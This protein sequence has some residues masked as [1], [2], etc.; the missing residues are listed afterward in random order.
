MAAASRPAGEGD[1]ILGVAPRIAYLPAGVDECAEVMAECAR[2]KLR[3]AFIGGGTELGLGRAP[4][5]LDA[6][7]RTERMPRILDYAPADMVLA[8]EAGATLAQVQAAAREHGQMLAIDPPR[9]DRAT[10]GGVVATGAFG[11]RRARYGAIRDLIIGVTL[12]RA[13]GVVARGGGKVVKN[14]AGFDLPKLAC[15]SLGTLGMIA[16]ATFRLHPLPEAGATAAF[17]GVPA[18]KVVELV[19]AARKAQLEP[20][21]AAALRGGDGRF[22][23]GVRFEGFAKGVTQQIARVVEVARAAG[24]AG[25]A[26][27]DEGAFWRRHDAA[28]TSGSLR[29]KLAALPARLTAVDALVAPLLGALRGGTFVW[30]ATLGFG[31]VCGDAGDAAAAA[32]ALDAARAGAMVVVIEAAPEELRAC[33]PWGPVPGSFAIMTELKRRF[34]P[35]RRL[36]PGR[37]VGGL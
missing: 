30:Y 31:F 10:I 13:D 28:R 37:F 21:A 22:D 32:T 25:E 8:A 29:V 16:T 3:V 33:D 17:V 2:E 20:C 19:A 18:A 11:P 27:A 23:L 12:V 1:A 24:I 9:P 36:N 4:E 5:R 26:L 34:D 14:V 35:E 6:V 15:G 7:V